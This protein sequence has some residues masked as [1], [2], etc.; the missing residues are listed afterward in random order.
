MYEHAGLM[1]VGYDFL[2]K[3]IAAFAV[4][5]VDV[6]AESVFL[7]IERSYVVQVALLFMKEGLPSP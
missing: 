5:V 7:N 6:I 4:D 3:P 2:F 1:R